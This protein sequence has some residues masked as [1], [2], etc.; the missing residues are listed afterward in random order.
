MDEDRTL[1]ATGMRRGKER[2]QALIFFS[3]RACYLEQSVR[4]INYG[5][6]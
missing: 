6:R 2:L 5:R 4:K 3:L 1:P